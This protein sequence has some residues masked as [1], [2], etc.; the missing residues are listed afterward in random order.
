M[1]FRAEHDDEF[2]RLLLQIQ[3]TVKQLNALLAKISHAS[4]RINETTHMV[5]ESSDQAVVGA[6]RQISAGKKVVDTISSMV[7]HAEYSE[8]NAS[9]ALNLAKASTESVT[10]G[11]K[12]VKES[13]VEINKL[14]ANVNA[15][16]DVITELKNESDNIS[17]VL[18]VI[19]NI[20]DQ[21]NLLALNAAIEAAR[22]G[23]NGR[24]FAVVADEVRSLAKKTQDST[25]EIQELIENIQRQADNAVAAMDIGRSTSLSSVE[26][27]T[28]AGTILGEIENNIT[29]IHKTNLQIEDS[30]KE[31]V[32]LAKIVHANI[33]L[34]EHV[35]KNTCLDIE[36]IN[37]ANQK[38]D[39]VAQE[40]SSLTDSF[41]VQ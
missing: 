16:A 1:E 39:G 29:S 26:K 24:G 41:T 28:S 19:R 15:A 5:L 22:A 40:L 7:S 6:H 14:S 38:L 21:T 17:V 34:M 20:A 13:V 23:E 31:Q 11:V 36:H 35:L 12:I 37:E 27:I 33:L 10:R 4:N 32:D 30:G 9:F 2:G 25:V 8:E 3:N 18:D